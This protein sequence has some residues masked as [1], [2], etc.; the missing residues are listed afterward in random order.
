MSQPI[1]HVFS[2]QAHFFTYTKLHKMFII[3]F[4]PQKDLDQVRIL[5][6]PESD[7]MLMLT[8]L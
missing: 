6:T 8:H 5:L 3:F 2:L 4:P 1:K 7:V